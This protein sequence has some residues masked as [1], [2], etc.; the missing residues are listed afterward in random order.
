[1]SLH[2]FTINWERF[3]P[4]ASLLGGALI[5]LSCAAYL[6]LAGR[7]AGI[8]G[9]VGSVVR[10]Q[11]DH[12]LKLSFFSAM[13]LTGAVLRPWL[14][15]AIECAAN[16]PIIAQA[17]GGLLVG[18]GASKQHGCTSGHGVCGLSRLSPKSLVAVLA[19]MSSGIFTGTFVRPHLFDALE[20]MQLEATSNNS[21]ALFAVNL[22]AAGALVIATQHGSAAQVLT[23]LVCGSMFSAGLAVSSMADPSKLIDFLNLLGPRGWDPSLAL[24]MAGAILAAF[25]PFQL[26]ARRQ[27]QDNRKPPTPT[28]FPEQPIG[29][30]VQPSSWFEHEHKLK[31]LAGAGMFGVGWAIAGQCPGPGLLLAGAGVPGASFVFVP[32]MVAGILLSNYV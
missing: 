32:S 4:L 20:Q 15:N 16:V 5:G 28:L 21:E 26:V 3:T 2:T 23:G 9:I 11:R 8:S 1:M 6:H 30:F 27:R 18:L 12:G 10:G 29:K 25:V 17:I 31:T 13:I 14:T 22:V 19:F 7:I 24:V